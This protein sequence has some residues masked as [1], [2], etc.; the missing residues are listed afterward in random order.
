[1]YDYD[2]VIVGG[3]LVGGSLASAL[4]GTSLRVA[5]IE[6]APLRSDGQPSY[7][8]RVIALSLGSR[9][10]FE[11]IGVWPAM[12]P[13]AEPI[14]EVRVSDRGHCGFT[15][16]H[17]AEEGAPALGY[18]TPARAM[19]QAIHSA[20]K[21]APNLEV[22]CPA[23][24][25]SHQVRANGVDLEVRAE[26]KTRHLSA[27]LLVAADGGD[28]AVRRH[29]DLK[30]EER[31]YGHDAIITTLTPDRPLRGL[32]FERFTESGPLAMLPMTGGRYSVVWT[33]RE[34][35]TAQLLALSDEDFLD[36]LQ[37]RFGYR[38]GRLGQVA[39]RHA[40]PL[41][42]LLTRDS[43]QERLVLIGNAAHTLHP[44]A[45]QGFNLGLRDVA[46]LAEVVVDAAAGGADIGSPGA[47][48]DY[49]QWRLHDQVG[50]AR[51][52]DGLARLF[53]VPWLPVRLARNLG[54]L[55]LDLV[56]AARHRLAER[57]MGLG[58]RLPRLA[59]GLALETRH[60]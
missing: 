38:L 28:S 15:S 59:R 25:L 2:L 43:V 56:P 27:R 9:R 53:V 40:Y 36:R 6:A 31:A 14:L 24:L 34:A 41:K 55:G 16:L 22:F 58:G 49:R 8:E 44:V 33:C 11:A 47:L 45:G 37:A 60:V 30:T 7:D 21:Y 20:L 3:G 12:E 4:S 18:V 1:M 52:T 42:L 57:F 54:M 19:G 39:P 32:A 26:G 13:E 51:L 48:A 29:L 10:I 46:A 35:D 50:T 23:Q 17:H 5:L